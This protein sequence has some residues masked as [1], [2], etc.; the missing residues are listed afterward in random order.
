MNVKL[1]QSKVFVKY[2][3]PEVITIQNLVGYIKSVRSGM[4]QPDA[5]LY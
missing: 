5:F 4:Y 1:M 3:L 2:L